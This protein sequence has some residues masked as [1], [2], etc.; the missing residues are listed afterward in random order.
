ME[1]TFDGKVA[2]VTG[3]GDEL[4]LGFHHARYFAQRGAKVVLNDLGLVVRC[5]SGAREG[6]SY[7]PMSKKTKYQS[8]Q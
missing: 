5:S 1:Q 6:A 2:L 3:A 8:K 7:V 4:G